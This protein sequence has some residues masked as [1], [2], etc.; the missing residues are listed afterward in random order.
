MFVPSELTWDG[1][2]SKLPYHNLFNRHTYA[3]P[4]Q[5][6]PSGVPTSLPERRPAEGGKREGGKRIQP[7]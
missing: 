1:P 2:V 6:V 7:I 4:F 3:V 5:G